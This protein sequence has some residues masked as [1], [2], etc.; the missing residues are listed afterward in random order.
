MERGSPQIDINFYENSPGLACRLEASPSRFP[1]LSRFIFLNNYPRKKTTLR[2]EFFETRLRLKLN[3]FFS[4]K[5]KRK[6]S[7]TDRDPIFQQREWAVN[8]DSAGAYTRQRTRPVLTEWQGK[9]SIQ[10]A[11]LSVPEAVWCQ[12]IGLSCYTPSFLFLPSAWT[13]GKRE[14][15]R[16]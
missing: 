14:G 9:T 2:R 4:P 16:F 8:Q 15:E 12:D 13:R 6:I 10:V 3:Q 11:E 1:S 7:I 5:E